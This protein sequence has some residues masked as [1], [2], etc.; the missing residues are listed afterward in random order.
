MRLHSRYLNLHYLLLENMSI[1]KLTLK[2]LLVQF[3]STWSQQILQFG[4]NSFT[5]TKTI[6]S[7]ASANR[8]IPDP[9]IGFLERC[10]INIVVSSEFPYYMVAKNVHSKRPSP[11]SSFIIVFSKG[12]SYYFFKRIVAWRPVIFYYFSNCF[13]VTNMVFPNALINYID[14]STAYAGGLYVT[15]A[16]LISLIAGQITNKHIRYGKHYIYVRN[17]EG[18]YNNRHALLAI[19]VN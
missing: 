8:T 7:S 16:K 5:T 6:L 2:D 15:H 3:T 1:L 19:A 12:C 11:H 17:F 9:H 10:T 14:S 18:K 4:K 13:F